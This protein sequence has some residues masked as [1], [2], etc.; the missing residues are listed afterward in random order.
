M[1][2]RL[3][4][5]PVADVEEVKLIITAAYRAFLCGEPTNSQFL[6]PMAIRF[7]SRSATLLSMAKKPASV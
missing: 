3:D 7:I 5:Q 4:V 1:L 2:P 6:R